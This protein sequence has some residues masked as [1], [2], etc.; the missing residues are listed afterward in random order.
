M[1]KTSFNKFAAAFCAAALILAGCSA[2]S[3]GRG[4][5]SGGSEGGSQISQTAAPDSGEQPGQELVTETRAIE[6]G[7]DYAINKINNISAED[8]LPGGYV[9]RDYDETTQ[10][11][12]FMNDKSK[13]I[14]RAYNYKEDL[15]DMAVWADAACAVIRISNVTSACDTKFDEPENVSVCGFDA[16]R[17]DDVIIQYEFVDNPD[18][19]NGERVKSE[20]CRYRGRN[21]F[22]YSEQDAYAVMFDTSEEDWDE[23]SALFEE[24]IADLEITKTEY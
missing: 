18:D 23:Q 10:G 2:D 24:F 21:Y 4:E 7:D 8:A 3:G 16:I 17:Y 15:Q 14:I 9:L 22:F 6:E 13:I 20:V 1:K 12:L 19:P 5:N 11:K